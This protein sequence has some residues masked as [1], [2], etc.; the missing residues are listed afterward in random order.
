KEW[1]DRGDRYLLAMDVTRFMME[2]MAIDQLT[3]DRKKRIPL[4]L[5]YLADRLEEIF[6]EGDTSAIARHST[7]K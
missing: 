3:V 2:G 5:D 7:S 1:N 6:K 4:L